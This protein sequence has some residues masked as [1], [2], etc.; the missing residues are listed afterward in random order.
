MEL[1]NLE[2]F[3]QVAELGSFTK[4]AKRLGYTQS[5]VS[6]QIRQLEEELGV[7]LFE[8]IHH[9]VR[10]TAKGRS[11]QRLA[12]EMLQAAEDMKR[13]AGESRSLK[14]TIRI[15]MAASLCTQLFRHDFTSFRQQHPDISL[16]VTTGKTEE[17]FRLLNQNEVDLVYT[18]D[19]HIYD[20]NYVTVSEEEVSVHFVASA[21]N[22]LA[23][24]SRVSP[25]ELIS[26]P[27]I[28]T[29]KNVSYRKLLDEYLASH[30]LELLPYLEIGDTSLI[31]S[32]VEAGMGISFL[33]DF[34]TEASV[35]EGR[36]I[37]FSVPEISVCIWKQLLY[38]R[39]KWVSPEM[40]AVMEY[41]QKLEKDKK[42]T[43]Y[44]HN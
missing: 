35:R 31:C 16:T 38:H 36:M 7:P 22:P 32:M 11:V 42:K 20:R 34:V 2:S 29:E 41:L 43:T 14:G 4:A 19:N 3:I 1:K 6:F 28:L 17:M 25:E 44:I 21:E 40:E 9:T 26:C 5:T 24:R 33:P 37:R 10:L 18:L 27:A 8:R 23:D 12:H 30:S 13:T 39:E 15:A